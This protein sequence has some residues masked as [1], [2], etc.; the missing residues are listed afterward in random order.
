MQFTKMQS[1]AILAGLRLLQTSLDNRDVLPEGISDI[2]TSAGNHDGMT[3]AE[4][5]S[6]CEEINCSDSQTITINLNIF[7][8]EGNVVDGATC[9]LSIDQIS[10]IVDHA[11]Q[12]AIVN[13]S[14]RRSSGDTDAILQELEEALVAADVV[15]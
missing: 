11:S 6:F 10:D 7:D 12:W 3:A 2:L 9:D 5:D 14:A 1:D 4:I 15:D 13:R 8:D